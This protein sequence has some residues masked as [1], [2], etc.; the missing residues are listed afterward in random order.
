[1]PTYS[2]LQRCGYG[3]PLFILIDDDD[4]T[5]DSY[6][7]RFGDKVVVI[8]NEA[9]AS[10]SD[11]FDNFNRHAILHA[12]N[13]C[14]DIAE[15][16]GYEYFLQLDDDYTG[17]GFRFPEE[18]PDG[19][20]KMN[21]SQT[22]KTFNDIIL[23]TINL[24]IKTGAASIAF[25]QGGDWMDG[26]GEGFSRRKCMNS[27]FCSTKRRFSFVGRANEDVNTYVWLGSRG[28]LFLTLP[29]LQV[30]Q[31]TT[32][33]CGGGTT[34]VYLDEGTYVK[35]F[36]TILCSPSCVRIKIMGSSN[37]RLHH[38]VDWDSAVPMIISEDYR[39]GKYKPE[40][41]S[42]ELLDCVDEIRAAVTLEAKRK[43]SKKKQQEV[44]IYDSVQRE[45]KELDPK[46]ND[47]WK[48]RG[49]ER[50]SRANIQNL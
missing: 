24:F 40:M 26:T 34:D 30:C 45:S 8:D 7:A 47:Y 46:W 49:F 1:M 12:R 2:L 19:S 43:K 23:A 44:K 18:L 3:G 31:R 48:E 29:H 38:K 33:K 4:E 27:F 14:F 42:P 39:K 36:F 41:A 50:D 6:R 20:I 5:A 15:S 37:R 28:Y 16:L 9:A 10:K 35:S 25:S 21:W 17:F 11:D 32:Q 22:R 13:A